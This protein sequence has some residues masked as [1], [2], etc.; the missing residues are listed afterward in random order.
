[1]IFHISKPGAN[2]LLCGGRIAENACFLEDSVTQEVLNDRRTC[3]ACI[4]AFQV[5]V[6]G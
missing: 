4:K 2:H 5:Q 3:P 6:G 1:M